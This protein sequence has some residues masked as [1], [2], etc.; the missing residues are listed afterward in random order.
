MLDVLVPVERFAPDAI[1]HLGR[2]VHD[3]CQHGRQLVIEVGKPVESQRDA[4]SATAV[5]IAIRDHDDLLVHVRHYLEHGQTFTELLQD[6]LHRVVSFL[7]RLYVQ[8]AGVQI[9]HLID[10]MNGD[11]HV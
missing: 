1:L 3:S 6:H 7:N 5:R 10:V 4:I 8:R 11:G 9:E 2:L